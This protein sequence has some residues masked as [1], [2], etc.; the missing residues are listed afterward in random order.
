MAITSVTTKTA[1]GKNISTYNNGVINISINYDLNGSMKDM[2]MYN[3]DGSIRTSYVY[4]YTLNK[5][6]SII[7]YDSSGAVVDDAEYTYNSTG[8]ASVITHYDYQHNVTSVDY[9]AAN[10][11]TIDHTV[12][13]ADPKVQQL[14]AVWSN[15][16]GNGSI[17]LIKALSDATGNKIAD[18]TTAGIS[19]GQDVAH[20]DDAWAAGFTGKGQ[21]IAVLDSGIDLTNKDLTA[22]ISKDSYNF[23]AKNSNVQD[24][25]GHGTFVASEI[26]AARNGDSVTGAAYDAELMVLKVADS[27]GSATLDNVVKGIYYAVDHGA[28]VINIS[29]YTV[30]PQPLLKAALEYANQHDVLV[31]VSAGNNGTNAPVYPAIYATSNDNVCAVGA[32]YKIGIDEGFSTISCKAGSNTEYNY[33]DAVGI[34]DVGYNLS[35]VTTM[36]GTSMAAPLV[37]SEMAIL[38]QALE[39][40][41]KY[42]NN[43][44]D[45]MVMNYVT[46]DTHSVQL[47]GIS[48]IA[49]VDHLFA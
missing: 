26:A 46:H 44:I 48:P 29:L 36:S 35:G 30:L 42:A 17:D 12:K 1:S 32:T 45:E 10:G 27:K 21:I 15:I 40:M 34:S 25:F 14:D 37:A 7:K 3:A 43:V 8:K 31:A 9:M 13:V 41:N 38:K 6:T 33:V 11:I 2:Y 4:K 22:H 24:D 23:V 49:G 47:V 39:S 16:T 20:F 5:L 19:W 18:T 28:D